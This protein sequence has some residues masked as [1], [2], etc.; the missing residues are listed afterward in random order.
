MQHVTEAGRVEVDQ[1]KLM[2][3]AEEMLRVVAAANA[4]WRVGRR[5]RRS[6]RP[7]F[8]VRQTLARRG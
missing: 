1:V 5:R 8:A 2:Q 7:M 6:R 3:A 4:A